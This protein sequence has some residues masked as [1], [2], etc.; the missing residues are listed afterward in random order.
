MKELE[1][2]FSTYLKSLHDK[3]KSFEMKMKKLGITRLNDMDYIQIKEYHFLY[4]Q[5]KLFNMMNEYHNNEIEDLK[6]LFKDILDAENILKNKEIE[7]G[8]EQLNKDNETNALLNNLNIDLEGDEYKPDGNDSYQSVKEVDLDNPEFIDAYNEQKELWLSTKT[9]QQQK[10]W[11]LYNQN[12]PKKIIAKRLNKDPKYIRVTIKRL[13]E[14]FCEDLS[15][16]VSTP[17]FYKIKQRK[18][19]AL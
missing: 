12:I 8:I 19:R 13:E 1:K 10:I 11:K 7:D 17:S 5:I 14:S 16:K 2:D 9:E 6:K 4:H 15:K 3:C 18:T